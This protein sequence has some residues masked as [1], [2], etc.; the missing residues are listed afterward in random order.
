M[1]YFHITLFNGGLTRK[2]GNISFFDILKNPNSVLEVSRN[3]RSIYEKMENYPSLFNEE[4]KVIK[5]A[6]SRLEKEAE[7]VGKRYNQRLP[8]GDED[9]KEAIDTFLPISIIKE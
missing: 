6:F 3:I 8:V 1:N 5:T 4:K 9:I 2:K 7:K